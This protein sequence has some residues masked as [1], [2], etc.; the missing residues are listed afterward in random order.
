[1]AVA[2]LVYVFLF[3]LTLGTA[4]WAALPQLLD[5]TGASLATT[6]IWVLTMLVGWLV[7]IMLFYLSLSQ[8]FLIFAALLASCLAY[9]TL[10]L[11]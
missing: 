11:K 9:F 10:N 3:G 6:I 2:L 5:K 8:V 7:P 4:T 1:M